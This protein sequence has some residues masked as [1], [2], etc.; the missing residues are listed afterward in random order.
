MQQGWIR[1]YQ[2][3]L[4]TLYRLLDGV[5]ILAT[6]YVSLAISGT[7]LTKDWL[8]AGLAVV[9]IFAFIAESACLYRSWRIESFR[10]LFV[11]TA[12]AWGGTCILSLVAAS[13]AAKWIDY[14]ESV[15]AG[16]LLL[17]LLVLTA[18]RYL[19]RLLLNFLR[20]HDHNTRS[21]AIIGLTE[22]GKNLARQLSMNAQLGIRLRGI[23]TTP[24]DMGETNSEGLS[25]LGDVT[26]AI[27]AARAG[28]LDIV[29]IALP[30]HQEALISSLLAAFS[31]TTATVHLLP[32]SL[33]PNLLGGKWSRIGD[34]ELI[35][36]YDTN[37]SG[38]KSALKRLE[39]ICVSSVAIL[40]LSPL[41]LAI[42]IAI[43]L[44]SPGPVI[45]RQRR[46]GYG[47]K[48][49]SVWKF[50]SMTVAENGSSVTQAKRND[51]RVTPLGRIL[52]RTSLDELP[53][54]FNVLYGSMS[55]VGPRPHA[56]AHNEQYRN[57]VQGYM[58]R[59]KVKP[60]MT[61]WAQVNGWRGETDT[62]HKMKMRIEHDLA[63]IRH[64]SLWLD[65]KIMLKTIFAGLSGANAY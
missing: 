49:I 18:W 53:Q 44:S 35:S 25:L 8:I 56:V 11:T 39:D 61:G 12:A 45:F 4:A 7:A 20:R 6:L 60:G 43:K 47:G 22:P 31:D 30:L 58:L 38:F 24:N 33:G 54:L 32:D 63:Y 3:D 37:I 59:H 34:T 10:K 17:S 40:L 16:W 5:L 9:V 52:R 15:A 64:W 62:L 48:V 41:M 21:A 29:Y 23:Y 42:A 50:R 36:I 55:I 27:A 1:A 26:S 57:L 46:Y 2:S 65:L 14:S 13:L 28:R 19:L 51:P